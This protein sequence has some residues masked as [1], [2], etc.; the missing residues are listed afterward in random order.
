ML[1]HN[2][3]SQL[4][5]QRHSCRTYLNRPLERTDLSALDAFAANWKAGP[6]GN[7]LRYRIVAATE[8]DSS[9]LRK[10][11][12]YGFIKNP[13]AFVVGAIRDRPGAMEDYGYVLEL[14]ILKAAD[15]QLGTCW[16]GITFTKS[17]FSQLMD[18]E[19]EEMIPAVIAIGYPANRQAFLDRV[20]R[21]YAGSDHRKPWQALFFDHFWDVALTKQQAGDFFEPLNLLRLAPSASNKQPWRI[22][23]SGQ[24]WHFYLER[25]PGYPPKIFDFLMGLAD[26]QRIDMG[27]AMAHFELGL[28]EIGHQGSWMVDDPK[29]GQPGLERTYIATWVPENWTREN[30][31]GSKER[32]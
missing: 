23:K 18:L 9:T 30:K 27:I 6:L 21:I 26:L 25:T 8:N 4:I 28:K 10:L 3:P 13:P 15:L 22:L 31:G 7:S 17:R 11:G 16:L 32:I 5:R 29:L 12:A 19:P 14:L 24:L 2:S 20:S 1:Y